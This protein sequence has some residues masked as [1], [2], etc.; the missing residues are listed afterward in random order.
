[1]QQS[2]FLATVLAA[3]LTL[4]TATATLAQSDPAAVVKQAAEALEDPRRDVYAMLALYADHALIDWGALCEAAPCVSHGKRM[5]QQQLE[6]QLAHGQRITMVRTH[7]SG[8]I[9]T[10]VSMLASSNLLKAGVGPPITVWNIIEVKDGKIVFARMGILHHYDPG[11]TRLEEWQRTQLLD[12][13]V[14]SQK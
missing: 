11:S 5:I 1:M 2:F 13:G 8:N 3:T 12:T 9:V 7:V 14:I 10:S 4:A 6:H